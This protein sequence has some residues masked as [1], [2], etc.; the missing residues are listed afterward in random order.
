MTA[1]ELLKSKPP[2]HATLTLITGDV[3]AQKVLMAWT[4]YKPSF[5]DRPLRRR[6]GFDDAWWNTWNTL[7]D[8]D[9]DELAKL[10]GVPSTLAAIVFYRLKRANLIYPDG[11]A[12]LVAIELLTGQV[13]AHIRRLLPKGKARAGA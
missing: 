1:L 13:M 12:A 8:M 9:F 11:T 7:R 3:A 4:I 6:E 5:K 2:S 10:S